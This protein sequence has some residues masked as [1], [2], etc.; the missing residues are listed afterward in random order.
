MTYQD[1]VQEFKALPPKECRYAI[2]IL[3]W[4]PV[5]GTIRSKT[6]FFHW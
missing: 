4:E 3:S 2:F 5:V 6:C 1:F